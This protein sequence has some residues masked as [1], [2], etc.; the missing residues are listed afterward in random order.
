MTVAGTPWMPIEGA[1]EGHA[2][3]VVSYHKDGSWGVR[4]DQKFSGKWSDPRDAE[5]RY[6]VFVPG[7]S[8]AIWQDISHSPSGKILLILASRPDG[9]WDARIDQKNGRKWL[10]GAAKGSKD[11][12]FAA[13][14]AP[15]A[16]VQ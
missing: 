12:Y 7:A 6:F 10:E 13:I 5:D 4:L 14:P 1:P 11:T 8:S 3:L 16:A 15:P 9:S 2:L